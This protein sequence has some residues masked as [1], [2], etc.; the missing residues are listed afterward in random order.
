MRLSIEI[1][2]GIENNPDEVEPIEG[3][4]REATFAQVRS[5]LVYLQFRWRLRNSRILRVASVAASSLYS[6][7]RPNIVLP[8]RRSR[9]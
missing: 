7:Q 6:A 1:V 5:I 3:T 4:L 2:P 8:G 9:L